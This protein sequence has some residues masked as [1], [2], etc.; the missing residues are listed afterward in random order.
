MESQDIKALAVR[1]ASLTDLLE[2]RSERAVREVEQSTDELQQTASGLGLHGRQ[3]AQEAVRS[4]GA[5]AGSTIQRG[6]H[7]AVEQCRAA[8]QDVKQE[9]VR[10]TTHLQEHCAA[11]RRSQRSA[12]WMCAFALSIGAVLA[13]GVAGYL[14][15]QAKASIRQAE[16]SAAIVDATRTGTLTQCGEALCVRTGKNPARYS[17]NNEYILLSR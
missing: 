2:Q 14:T 8:L 4:I 7:E 17:R 1:L 10:T 6:L 15:W 5:Q 12:L 16:F 3:L 13:A 11:V 9:A